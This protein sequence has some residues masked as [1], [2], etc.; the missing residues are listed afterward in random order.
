MRY[1]K[2]ETS[3]NYCGCNSVLY[4]AV[5][6]E[7]TDDRIEELAWEAAI[8]EQSGYSYLA[9]KDIYEDE[10][11]TE[12]A[13]MEAIEAAQEE[14]EQEIGYNWSEVSKE[15]FEENNGMVLQIYFKQAF[16]PAFI[17]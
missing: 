5:N 4:Y 7:M 13:Y 8:D 1:I 17:F 12:E 14:F 9:T 11:E 10:Y 2:I 3:C 6:D 15:E 16:Q